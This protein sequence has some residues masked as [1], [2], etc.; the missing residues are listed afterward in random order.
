MSATAAYFPF[1]F[2]ILLILIQPSIDKIWFEHYRIEY[3][4][5]PE[6]DDQGPTVRWAA[7]VAAFVP[8]SVLVVLGVALLLLDDPTHAAAIVLF[9]DLAV[10][11]G[12][13]FTAF[14]R[15]SR[16]SPHLKPKTIFRDYTR[17]QLLLVILNLIGIGIAIWIQ[18]TS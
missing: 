17:L 12:I 6:G 18:A 3:P 13:I 2:G 11:L 10:G 7:D 9:L 16:Q 5:S 8:A 1:A 4:I 14:V 15:T